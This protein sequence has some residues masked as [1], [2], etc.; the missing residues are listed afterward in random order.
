[1]PIHLIKQNE[2]KLYVSKLNKKKLT[3]RYSIQYRLHQNKIY[4][5][6]KT[7]Y[8]YKFL[9]HLNII[10]EFSGRNAMLICIRPVTYTEINPI[11]FYADS[12]LIKRKLI[13]W[14]IKKLT[15]Y[16]NIIRCD[17][18]HRQ[19]LTT[20]LYLNFKVTLVLYNWCIS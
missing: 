15:E 7:S 17:K 10:R 3:K 9:N 19:H 2:T 20:R 6:F 13:M 14:I 8:R 1:M 18:N 5:D 4:R 16:L 11:T 12:F